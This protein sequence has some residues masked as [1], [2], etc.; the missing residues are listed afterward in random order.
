MQ[1][2]GLNGGDLPIVDCSLTSLHGD[3]VIV[4]LY[5]EFT[6]IH[7]PRKTAYNAGVNP[8]ATTPPVQSVYFNAALI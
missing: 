6:G 5:G 7:N 2:I 3:V 4:E 8:I 1:G